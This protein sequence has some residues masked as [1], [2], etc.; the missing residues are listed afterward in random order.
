MYHGILPQVP[1]V[2]KGILPNIDMPTPHHTILFTD[3]EQIA[4]AERKNVLRW[5]RWNLSV[6]SGVNEINTTVGIIPVAELVRMVK[7]LIVLG[8]VLGV[9]F[10]KHIELYL[11]LYFLIPN[12]RN[13]D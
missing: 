13:V 8:T 9:C 1:A 7:M 12:N 2:T 6:S 5:A 10:D 11:C 3:Q 4:L